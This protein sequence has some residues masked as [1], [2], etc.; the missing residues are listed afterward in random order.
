MLKA[1][2]LPKPGKEIT[3]EGAVALKKKTSRFLSLVCSMCGLTEDEY[4]RFGATLMYPGE[5]VQ[6]CRL[7][8]LKHTLLAME[9]ASVMVR[10]EIAK[11]EAAKESEES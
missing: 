10:K 9:K 5:G 1:R 11:M 8:W 3:V 2:A 7:S 4:R 6:C